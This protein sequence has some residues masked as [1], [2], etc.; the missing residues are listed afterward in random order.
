MCQL[1]FIFSGLCLNNRQNGSTTQHASVALRKN[2]H[3]I[4]SYPIPDEYVRISVDINE[5]A[6]CT[7]LYQ[8]QLPALAHI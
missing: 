1:F 2:I 7:R 3:K 6:L 4:E 8:F 5:V